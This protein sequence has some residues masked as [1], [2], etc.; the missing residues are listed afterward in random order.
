MFTRFTCRGYRNVTADDVELGP[1]TVLLG[2][3]NCGRRTSSGR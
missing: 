2:P 1:L 3:N